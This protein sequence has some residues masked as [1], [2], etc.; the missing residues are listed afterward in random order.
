M[1]RSCWERAHS[2]WVFM[3]N[4]IKGQFIQ[5]QAAQKVNKQGYYNRVPL[6]LSGLKI[7][8]E[9]TNARTHR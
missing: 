7:H 1:S 5:E 8:K 3:T 6:S 2:N 9:G 4:L